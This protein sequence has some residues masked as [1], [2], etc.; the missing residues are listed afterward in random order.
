M[1]KVWEDALRVLQRQLPAKDYVAWIAPIRPGAFRDGTA[2]LEVPNGFFRDWVRQYF[3]QS[4]TDALSETSGGPC[5]VSLVVNRDVATPTPSGGTTV[6]PPGQ[7]DRARR[8]PVVGRLVSNYTLDGFV[9]GPAN[10]VAAGAAADVAAEPGRRYNPLFIHGGVGLGKSHLLNAV[11][12]AALTH[13]PRARVGCLTAEVFVNSM[14][15][16]LRSDQMERFRARFRRI[17]VLIIDDVQFLGG[18]VRSQEEFFHTFN[19]LHE[20]RKQIVLASD[21]APQEIRDLEDC[22]RSRFSSGLSAVVEPPDSDLRAAIIARKAMDLALALDA[23]LCGVIADSTRGNVREI[24]GVLNAIRARV[25]VGGG[26][27]TRTIVHAV[28]GS[29]RTRSGASRAIATILEATAADFGITVAELT[30]ARRSARIAEARQ[31]ATFLCRELTE[32]PLAAIGQRVGGRD[33]STVLYAL[34]RVEHR[35]K[36]DHA[37]RARVERLLGSLQDD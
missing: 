25:A 29:A 19:A 27:V 12:H 17:D 34:R 6:R 15:A 16:A 26:R 7:S 5:Q 31:V 28:L 24:E 10:E 3:M 11:G 37:F 23:E 4:L 20:G 36:T 8:G 18:K 22:L 9:V 13:R 35:R 21:R 32:L 14:I 33:H 2:T 30:S 1:A